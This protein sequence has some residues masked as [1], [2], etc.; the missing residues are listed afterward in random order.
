MV[1]SYIEKIT[2]L[3]YPSNLAITLTSPIPHAANPYII[4]TRVANVKNQSPD[5]APGTCAQR[6]CLAT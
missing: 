1:V 4:V 2:A 3:T 5:L 6:D